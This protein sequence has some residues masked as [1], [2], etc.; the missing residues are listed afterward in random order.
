VNTS[1]ASTYILSINENFPVAGQKNDSRG[2]KDNFYNIKSALKTIT[3]NINDLSIE[4]IAQYQD[5]DISGHN[6]KNLLIK[7]G[8]V[9]AAEPGD[10]TLP[11]DYSQAGYWPITLLNSGTNTLTITNMPA[12]SG[13]GILIVS[14][15]TVTSNTSV[16]FTTTDPGVTVVSL[17]PEDQPFELGSST[18]Y[19]FKFW[20]D[21]SD[22]YIYIKKISQDIINPILGETISSSVVYGET[23][24]FSRF[25]LGSLILTDGNQDITP[26]AYGTLLSVYCVG[27]NQWGIFADG[28][29]NTYNQLVQSNSIA[30]GYIPP[31]A[32]PIRG[33]LLSAYCDVFNRMGIYADGLNGTYRQLIEANSTSCGYIPPIVY[34]EIITGPT[35]VA[36]DQ[37]I[38]VVV[39]G[40]KPNTA[41][42]L[43]ITSGPGSPGVSQPGTLNSI[44]TLA[45]PL[46]PLSVAGTYVFTAN[47]DGTGHTATYTV[48]SSAMWVNWPSTTPADY[49]TPYY[50]YN[51]TTNIG[52]YTGAWNQSQSITNAE[53]T[54]ILVNTKGKD[55]NTV[56]LNVYRVAIETYDNSRP[57]VTINWTSFDGNVILDTANPG[58]GFTV[59][60]EAG[61][62]QYLP[63]LAGTA[64]AIP[65]KYPFTITASAGSQ[66]STINCTL[67]VIG[68]VYNE[69]INGPGSVL[70]DQSFTVNVTGGQPNTAVTF[71]LKTGPGS[72]GG[73]LS[74]MLDGAGSASFSG[75]VLTQ[76]ATYGFTAVFAANGHVRSY[77][78]TAI[79]PNLW[80][81]WPVVGLTTY[82][83]YPT[84]YYLFNAQSD[85]GGYLGVWY[86]GQTL[87]G[88][89]NL[90][91]L[92]NLKGQGLNTI[93]NTPQQIAVSTYN[94][95]APKITVNWTYN[96]GSVFFDKNSQ[97]GTNGF[98]VT[99]ENGGKQYLPLFGGIAP[100][101]PGTYTFDITA[102]TALQVSTI[103]CSLV[104]MAL[105]LPYGTLISTS[106]RGYDKWGTYSN[107]TGGTF[108][109]IIEANSSFCGWPPNE[110]VSGP[111]T[112]G[113][114]S[115]FTINI[116]NG[117]PSTGFSWTVSKNGG[118]AG[119]VT[120][121]NLNASGTAVLSNQGVAP[122]YLSVG[123]YTYT[124][125]FAAT[126]HTRTYTITVCTAAGTL[127]S[128]YCSGYDQYGSYANGS[129]G[130]YSQLIQ[131]N[132]GACGWPPAPVVYNE[133]VSGPT[134]VPP[135]SSTNIT[136][137]GGAP[138]STVT[139]T[140]GGISAPN[141]RITLDGSGSG[142]FN[143]FIGA[144]IYYRF[145][146]SFA[147]T[148]HTRTLAIAGDYTYDI[149][150][151]YELN[152][153]DA[154]TAF[155]KMIGTQ[156]YSSNN[157]FTVTYTATPETRWG[158]YRVPDVGG[159]IF[160]MNS[161][162]LSG[163]L[164][165]TLTQE[166]IN[167]LF[168]AADQQQNNP[169]GGDYYRART[170]N[171]AQITVQPPWY[172]DFTGRPL[173]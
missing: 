144:P 103:T 63:I 26:P 132:S 58:T 7:N 21:Y 32:P 163:P 134:N 17:G 95:A 166:V 12:N 119:A 141:N 100:A 116:S 131:S 136:V 158:F 152:L 113:D 72:P 87:T 53:S 14:I 38:D 54:S 112:S 126:S 148:G 121:G 146:F 135:L 76:I 24:S 118:A 114:N 74:A 16:M 60:H 156:I 4:T 168:Y 34:N 37:N 98:A 169:G 145:S 164:P 140:S 109:R 81:N 149:G 51:T 139:E 97:Y 147:A 153:T 10:G 33:T 41:F 93:V 107:G 161:F 129:G 123:T 25:D 86:P 5:N 48:V 46:A 40:G 61:T 43:Q 150:L 111:A 50:W 23:A 167:A 162:A 19:F 120:N 52:G 15:S 173:G 105:G 128:T 78:V 142:T 143:A 170:P 137:T 2:F 154:Q 110:A 18:P 85:I 133:V 68:L 13:T 91:Q 106:C 159:L 73:V 157:A 96:D 59:T 75:L 104:V 3:N 56:G 35:V 30:C 49:T 55:L 130:T 84:P 6:F 45:F 77:T 82:A 92:V 47:F 117:A 64:P 39:S 31:P 62:T 27:L 124:F 44:G 66:H 11:I 138:F 172:G 80:I 57:T 102:S 8:N 165:T 88:D 71:Q 160:W 28:L 171:K 36:T 65:G 115:S 20:N 125:T 122:G 42:T 94:N 89:Q 29:G 90:I 83:T 9:T 67:L 155:V 99:F 22:P 151:K 108:D 70:V 127:L 101:T 1:T 69:V 79:T